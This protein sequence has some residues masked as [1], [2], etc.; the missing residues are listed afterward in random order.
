MLDCKGKWFDQFQACV[1]P[2]PPR[3]IFLGMLS[4]L[5]PH[6]GAF[7]EGQP[8]VVIWNSIPKS[9]NSGGNSKEQR[10]GIKEIVA[11]NL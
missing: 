10:I 7:S 11:S 2:P 6:D 4:L 9:P 5:F 8:R 3:S 1:S